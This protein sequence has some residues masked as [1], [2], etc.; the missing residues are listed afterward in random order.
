MNKLTKSLLTLLATIACAAVADAKTFQIP[1]EEAPVAYVTFPD[2]WNPEEITDGVAGNSPDEAVFLAAV[3]VSSEK[4]MEAELDDTFE[5]LKEHK[6][7][8]DPS[9]K[10]ENK[11]E[12]NGLE[13]NELLFQGRDDDGPTAVSIT[14]VT[15]KDKL[16]VL[17]YW[18]SVA[19]EAKHQADVMK[20]VR[21]LKPVS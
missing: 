5:M 6:V 9:T 2:T 20:I 14:F 15:I 11:F 17:T 4:G 18:V 21:S 19:D 12:I 8:L 7:E 13:A 10:K 16:V 3:A 1:N